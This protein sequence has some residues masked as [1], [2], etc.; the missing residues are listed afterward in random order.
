MC[1]VVR[2]RGRRFD[3]GARSAQEAVRADGVRRSPCAKR[4]SA[5][6][7]YRTNWKFNSAYVVRV[8][9]CVS[10]CGARAGTKFGASGRRR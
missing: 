8:W 9:V 1:V 7:G 3:N 4:G 6:R 2:G 5:A 10:I